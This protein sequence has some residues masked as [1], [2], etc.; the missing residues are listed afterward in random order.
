MEMSRK[1]VALCHKYGIMVV[2]GMI[3]GFP[4]DDEE[5]IIKNYRFL[6]STGADSYYCQ[7]LTSLSEDGDP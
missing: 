2:G 4:D 1:A 6:K 7:M 5:D 3:F